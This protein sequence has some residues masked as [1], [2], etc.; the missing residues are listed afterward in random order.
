MTL[1]EWRDAFRIGIAEVDH[2]HQELITL[3]NALHAA[4]Q[5]GGKAAIADFLGE[6]HSSIAAHFALEEKLMRG[7]RYPGFTEHKKDHEQLLDEIREIMDQ[8]ELGGSY[9]AARLATSL[10]SWF[11]QHF[12][13]QDARW[14]TSIA[15]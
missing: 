14:H 15:G 6:L 13:T 1:L 5:S 7:Q 12:R 2:E 4:S 3:I 9:D 8:A 11:S 10:E